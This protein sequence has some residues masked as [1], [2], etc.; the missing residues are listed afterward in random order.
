MDFLRS[1][2][3]DTYKVSNYPQNQPTQQVLLQ[4]YELQFSQQPHKCLGIFAF[5]LLKY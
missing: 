1:L 2:L 4:L 3:Q 5:T